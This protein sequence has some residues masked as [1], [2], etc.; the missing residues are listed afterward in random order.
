MIGC[1]DYV[2]LWVTEIK[3][4]MILCALVRRDDVNRARNADHAARTCERIIYF[5]MKMTRLHDIHALQTH[6]LR[7]SRGVQRFMDFF[8]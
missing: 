1:S 3:K 5:I 4:S 2:D 8:S 7:N 6:F